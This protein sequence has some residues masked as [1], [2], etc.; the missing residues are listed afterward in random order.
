VENP[1]Y[2]CCVFIEEGGHGSAAAAPVARKILAKAF[3]V[4]AGAGGAAAPG[5]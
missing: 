2:A 4:S 1:R 5:D 3:G